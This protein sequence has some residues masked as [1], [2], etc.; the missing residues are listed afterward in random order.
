MSCGPRDGAAGPKE[1]SDAPRQPLSRNIKVLIAVS[2]LFG[3]GTG[4][5]EFVLPFYLKD[6]GLSYPSMGWLFAVSA[7]VMIVIRLATGRLVDRWG[8]KRPYLI[9]ALMSGG[10]SALTA[11]TGNVVFLTLLKTGRE[12]GLLLR[13]TVHP[14]LLYLENKSRFRD[15]IGKTRGLEYGSAALGTAVAGTSVLLWGT[16]GSLGIGGL[17]LGAAAVLLA[18]GIRERSPVQP[19]AAARAPWWRWDVDRNLKIIMISGFVFN[20]G[21]TMSHGFMMP[22]FF[23]ARFNADEGSVAVVLLIHRLTPVLPLLVAGRLRFRNLKMAYLWSVAVEG[24]IIAAGGMIPWFVPAAAVWLLHDVVGAGL[25]TP[26]QSEIIQRYCRESTRGLDLSKTLVLSSAGG[27]I[28]P[29]I[30]GFLADRWISAPF[31]ASG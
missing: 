16:G 13:D 6:R 19:A 21:L 7:A 9:A 1:D 27:A 18:V 2:I 25:W 29:V 4:L 11:L 28:G 30:A 26:I 20:L 22:L 24:A 5:Y 14:V 15:T 17:I 10:S 23:S 8:C 12:I 3:A 31:I